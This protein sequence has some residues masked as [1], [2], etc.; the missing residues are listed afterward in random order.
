MNGYY[1]G[2]KHDNTDKLISSKKN[3]HC[4]IKAVRTIFYYCVYD[5]NVTSI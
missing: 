4:G 2:V 5:S 3:K 1:H